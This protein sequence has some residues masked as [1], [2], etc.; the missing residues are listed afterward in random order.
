MNSIVLKELDLTECEEQGQSV[1]TNRQF[2]GYIDS[3]RMLG[4]VIR[5]EAEIKQVFY[6]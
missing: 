1:L 3:R 4:C 6:P 5:E 2:L